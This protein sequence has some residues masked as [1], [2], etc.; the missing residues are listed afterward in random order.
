MMNGLTELLNTHEAA[1]YTGFNSNTLRNTRS[2]GKLGG[3]EAPRFCKFGTIVRYRRTVL[4]E[5]LSQFEE[6]AD[7]SDN[8]NEK[9]N[10]A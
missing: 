9:G 6:T 7:E 3:T 5:W 10:V 4:D 1:S 8:N 2:T